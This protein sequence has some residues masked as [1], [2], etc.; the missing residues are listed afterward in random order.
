MASVLNRDLARGERLGVYGQGLAGNGGRREGGGEGEKKLGH[1]IFSTA[2]SWVTA[3]GKRRMQSAS[4][5]VNHPWW[6]WSSMVHRS[7]PT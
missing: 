1:R 3:N 6:I 7:E 2:L 4:R 5:C